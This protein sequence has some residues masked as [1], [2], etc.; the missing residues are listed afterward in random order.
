M[1]NKNDLVIDHETLE[2]CGFLPNDP[3][4]VHVGENTVLVVP[5]SMTAM[6]TVNTI[7]VLSSI[8]TA[9]LDALRDVCGTCGDQL[10][11]DICPAG[12]QAPN[13]CP[14]KDVRGPLVTLSESIRREMGIA[15]DA[16]V[17]CFVDEGELVVTAA[18]HDHDITDVPESVRALL[19]FA[20]VCP[21]RLD[22]VLRDGTGVWY[23]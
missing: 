22:Q 1:K 9:L 12:C 18:D 16:K 15:P 23:G 19:S 6:E 21:G 17:D 14:Y 5:E 20:G 7:G 8:L 13:R 2:V 11:E 3:L 10:K 4:S